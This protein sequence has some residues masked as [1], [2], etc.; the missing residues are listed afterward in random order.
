MRE[1][2]QT[3]KSKNFRIF[4]AKSIDGILNVEETF[5]TGVRDFIEV[6]ITQALYEIKRR[7]KNE[8]SNNEYC[9]ATDD[10]SVVEQYRDKYG[11]ILIHSNYK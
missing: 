7:Q 9:I 5:T 8:K 1:T 6:P 2:K 10:P 4:V 11:I 3:I